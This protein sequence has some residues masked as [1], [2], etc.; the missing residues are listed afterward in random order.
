MVTPERPVD[1]VRHMCP[2]C[3]YPPRTECITCSGTGLVTV[4]ELHAYEASWNAAIRSGAKLLNPAAQ[5]PR[6]TV[7]APRDVS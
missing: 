6:R 1:D 7:P 4:Q 2:A 5:G 3:G